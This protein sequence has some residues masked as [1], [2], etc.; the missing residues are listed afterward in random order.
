[1]L[2][3]R[4]SGQPSRFT[5]PAVDDVG[6][7]IDATAAGWEL[8]DERGTSIVAGVVSDF[9]PAATHIAFDLEADDLTL[10]AGATSAGRELV[11]FLTTAGGEIELRDFFVLVASNPLKVAGNSFV[12]YAEALSLRQSFG[13]VLD[14]WD[15]TPDRTQR[16]QA[17]ADAYERLLRMV[18]RLPLIDPQT[19]ASSYAAYGTGTDDIFEAYRR[20][21]LRGLSLADFDALPEDFR[22]AIKRAQLV[23]ADVVLGGDTVS[24]KRRDGIISETVGES[25][26]F[27][28]TKPYL[29]LPVSRQAFEELRRYIIFKVGV[30]RA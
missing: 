17:L 21:K 22:R 1:M 19:Q 28:S 25:S 18:Y 9:D 23:E 6:V 14:A 11:V 20:V 26:S 3:N 10:P 7:K 15:A 5:I 27:Y 29:N 24:K 4:T 13:N 2:A 30:A 16:S 8:F 12:S